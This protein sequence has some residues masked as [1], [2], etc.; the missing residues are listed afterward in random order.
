[1]SAEIIDL[2]A[3]KQRLIEW[4]TDFAERLF[5]QMSDKD[6]QFLRQRLERELNRKE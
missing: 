1:V 6:R 2:E 3:R 5:A 4:M